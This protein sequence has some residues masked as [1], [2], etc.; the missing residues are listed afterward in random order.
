MEVNR[1]RRGG[2]CG[3]SPHAP[4]L[5]KS[6]GNKARVISLLYGWSINSFLFIQSRDT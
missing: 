5:G 2:L 6:E 4:S 3:T 1:L